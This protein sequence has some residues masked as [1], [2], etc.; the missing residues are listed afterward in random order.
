MNTE[1]PHNSEIE[2][3]KKIL[4]KRSFLYLASFAD[5]INRYIDIRIKKQNRLRYGV[6]SFLITRGGTLTHTRLARLMFRS[7]HSVTKVIDNL[8]KNG[9]VIREPEPK[10][11][12]VVRIRITSHGLN[13]V[14][15]TL[16]DGDK[17]TKEAM[18]CLN[19][20]ELETL[21]NLIKKLREG[22]ID[23]INNC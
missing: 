14:S 3:V 16:K 11:R 9:L 2:I 20:N 7:K 17:I 8:E 19:K 10:D 22:M 6:L 23:K 5:T 18:S 1:L 15:Q 12:R 13:Y 21:I 4:R